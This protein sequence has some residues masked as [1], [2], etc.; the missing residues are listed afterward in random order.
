MFSQAPEEFRQ[1]FQEPIRRIAY[2]ALLHVL[3]EERSML[4]GPSHRP[5]ENSSYVRAGS[6]QATVTIQ[7]K[8]KSLN[9]P[10]VRQV[11]PQ[12]GQSSE[13]EL[14]SW[15]ALKDDDSTREAVQREVLA[16]VSS[17]V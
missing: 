11:D 16:G 2:Q 14:V 12:T 5:L 9:R 10:R 13:V 7:G 15:R 6:T 8:R 17:A 4:C 1:I 3:E